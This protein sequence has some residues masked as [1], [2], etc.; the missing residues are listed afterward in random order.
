MLKTGRSHHLLK[1]LLY[2][3]TYISF[4]F[5]G[6]F[7]FRHRIQKRTKLRTVQP[8]KIVS[9]NTKKTKS[10]SSINTKINQSDS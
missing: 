2:R 5:I 8:C 4:P 7:I 9:T 10:L 1:T 3:L 6:R